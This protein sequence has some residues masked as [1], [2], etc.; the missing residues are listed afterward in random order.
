MV[1]EQIAVKPRYADVREARQKSGAI[2]IQGVYKSFP[3][4][5]A[6]DITVL[7]NINLRFVPGEFIS[8]I[9]PWGCG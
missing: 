5:E 7:D 6:P 1:I 4:P 9:G 8:L 3:Q 2:V